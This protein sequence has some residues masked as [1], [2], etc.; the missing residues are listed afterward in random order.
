MFLGCIMP[1]LRSSN[2]NSSQGT[3]PPRIPLAPHLTRLRSPFRTQTV[4]PQLARTALNPKPLHPSP[5][6]WNLKACV[7]ESSNIMP[8]AGLGFRGLGLWPLFVQGTARSNGRTSRWQTLLDTAAAGCPR[9][10]A[11]PVVGPSPPVEGNAV[12][13]LGS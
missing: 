5:E 12:T 4:D 3:H 10:L 1:L 8:F 9:S 2:Q 6:H 7:S 11:P 13:R